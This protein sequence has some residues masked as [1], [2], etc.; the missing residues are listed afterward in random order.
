[1][2]RYAAFAAETDG[3]GQFD[4]QT[5]AQKYVDLSHIAGAGILDDLVNKSGLLAGI[6]EQTEAPADAYFNR[7]KAVLERKVQGPTI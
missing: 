6:H 5:A 4:Y 1:M 3:T 7:L 2:E